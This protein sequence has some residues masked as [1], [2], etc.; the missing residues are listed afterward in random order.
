MFLIASIPGAIMGGTLGAMSIMVL[1]S[2]FRSMH[3]EELN[4][5]NILIIGIPVFLTVCVSLLPQE[6]VN[7][8][9]TLLSFLFSSSITIGALAAVIVN[10]VIPGEKGPIQNPE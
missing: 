3:H 2:G 4:D 8:M 7:S 5:R 1:M 6:M 9:P 10:L